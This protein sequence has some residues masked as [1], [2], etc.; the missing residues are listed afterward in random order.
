MF[1]C[2]CSIILLAEI[3]LKSKNEFQSCWCIGELIF[4]F[5]LNNGVGSYIYATTTFRYLLF[6]VVQLK[7]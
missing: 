7:F 6:A 4:L 2:A 1:F 3:L 5:I